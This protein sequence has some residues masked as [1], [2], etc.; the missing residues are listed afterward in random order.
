MY[1]ALGDQ[2]SV[3]GTKGQIA[4]ILQSQG[5]LPG[6]LALYL[7]RLTMAREMQD[8]DTVGHALMHCAQIRLERGDHKRGEIQT[9][10]EELSEAY[11]IS[12]KL[13][14]P[15]FIGR[16]GNLLGQVLIMSGHPDQA[17]DVLATAATA[18]EK[19]G[20]ADAAAYCRQ[21]IEQIRGSAS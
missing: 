16:A 18:C 4:A 5:D 2:R 14:R 11:T 7:E 9:I 8:I 17:V 20:H 15:D 12:L 3:A 1:E 6:A 13:Q 10:F 21:L 19:I